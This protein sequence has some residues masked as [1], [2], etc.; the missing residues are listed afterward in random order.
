M[1]LYEP[2]PYQGFDRP[3]AT[4]EVRVMITDFRAIYPPWLDGTHP[5][6][7]EEAAAHVASL[8]DTARDYSV[9]AAA[10][11]EFHS[12]H[13]SLSQEARAWFNALNS[14]LDDVGKR[15]FHHWFR[16]LT[17]DERTTFGDALG[18]EM[19]VTNLVPSWD[20]RVSTA[21]AHL[22]KMTPEVY[23][24][25]R[26]NATTI[27]D[28]FHL[29]PPQ[30][31]GLRDEIIDVV[32]HRL[33]TDNWGKAVQLA[34]RLAT[35]HGTGLFAGFDAN[36]AF[37]PPQLGNLPPV[38]AGPQAWWLQLPNNMVFPDLSMN[39]HGDAAL[40]E[41]PWT[42]DPNDPFALPLDPTLGDGSMPFD[43]AT[44]NPSDLTL[45]AGLGDGSM[46]LDVTTFDPND[47][48]GAS[49][50]AKL[51]DGSMPLDVA[52]FDPGDLTLS[53]GLGDGSMPFD[54][55]TVNPGDLTL[56]AGLGDGSAPME[57]TTV[58]P[59]D[60]MG[61]PT[62]VGSM[63]VDAAAFNP[64]VPTNL[65]P[66]VPSTD[67]FMGVQRQEPG[68]DMDWTAT[69]QP[70]DSLGAPWQPTD[71]G[72]EAPAVAREP[73][74]QQAAPEPRPGKRSR[75]EFEQDSGPVTVP[76]P[77]ESRPV[78]EQLV[79]PSAADTAALLDAVPPGTRFA[80]PRTFAGLINGTRAET[81]RDVNC[82]DAGLAFHETYHGNPRVAGAK[83]SPLVSGASAVAEK[84]SYAPELLSR[85]AAGVAEVINRIT[86]AGHGADALVFGYPRKGHGHVWNVVNHHGVVSIVDAQAGTVVPATPDALPGLD[87]VYAIP[88]DA[89][90]EFVTGRPL[91]PPTPPTDPDPYA[92]AE[93]ERAVDVHRMRAAAVAGE[94]IP[95][96]GTSGRLVPSL[97][98]LRLIGAAIAAEVAADLSSVLGRN[99]IAL[100]I[101]PDAEYPE[102][103]KFTPRGRPLPV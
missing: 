86:E 27:V 87:R 39:L 12:W 88:L 62:F 61:G 19:E 99:V 15:D 48:L 11:R 59:R 69:H 36:A 96:R 33:S 67:P 37:P 101:G 55:A 51:G 5:A 50:F 31:D 10:R 90:G 26:N 92:A 76:E 40:P 84:L 28:V 98:G 74:A 64:G 81:G 53:G 3:L 82:V 20:D 13:Q 95:V 44:V 57:V 80:D 8:Q 73:D 56:P 102:Y 58:N 23:T 2:Q 79:P 103:M 65:P 45:P 47:L 77:P 1:D 16:S 34:E 60:L 54:V 70:T 24:T 85:G 83:N 14:L 100:V 35:E 42:F 75:D 52:T 38:Q 41:V 43:V 21:Q 17:Q 63:P 71:T 46:P 97:D 29:V 9:E 32:T 25:T 94:E 72:P 22:G 49:A 6:T 4:D 7:Q 93:Y 78:P 66:T 18:R 91:D 30:R 89:D 68:G